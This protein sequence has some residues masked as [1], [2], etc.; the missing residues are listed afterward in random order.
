MIFVRRR[1]CNL[2]SVTI[3][4]LQYMFWRQVFIIEKYRF[5]D[6]SRL[7]YDSILFKKVSPCFGISK[8]TW[9]A[10]QWININMILWY[11]VELITF[12]FLLCTSSALTNDFFL[13]WLV[14]S[15]FMYNWNIHLLVF[16]H[17]HS[18]R[19]IPNCQK[20]RCRN[21]LSKSTENSDIDK[22]I[23]INSN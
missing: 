18:Q 3:L 14:S 13:R 2:L 16:K 20:Y 23:K 1:M 8:A 22:E 17:K 6:I 11:H 15:P 10:A 19:G 5:N 4:K 9:F 21:L 7:C 12:T